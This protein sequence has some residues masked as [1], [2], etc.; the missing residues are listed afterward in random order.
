MAWPLRCVF[1]STI[2]SNHTPVCLTMIFL[3]FWFSRMKKNSLLITG[4]IIKCVVITLMYLSSGLC[5]FIKVLP[6]NV[7]IWCINSRHVIHTSRWARL[8]PWTHTL[9]HLVNLT[10]LWTRQKQQPLEPSLSGN[11]WSVASF[12]TLLLTTLQMLHLCCDPTLLWFSPPTVTSV[13]Y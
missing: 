2:S 9:L 12:N 6:S 4:C 1:L 11:S 13:Q 3:D 10:A 7:R 8:L 5:Y